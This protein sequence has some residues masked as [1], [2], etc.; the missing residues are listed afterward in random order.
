MKH[1][2]SQADRPAVTRSHCDPGHPLNPILQFKFPWKKYAAS[3]LGERSVLVLHNSMNLPRSPN[4]GTS[5]IMIY[6][7]STDIYM[8]ESEMILGQPHIKG[9]F[10][11]MVLIYSG[12]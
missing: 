12:V 2:P 3:V 7:V 6:K 9:T 5:K 10:H 1:V 8:V 11:T 4:R